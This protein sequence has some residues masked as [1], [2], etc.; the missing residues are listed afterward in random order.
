LLLPLVGVLALVPAVGSTPIELAN[1]LGGAIGIDLDEINNRLYFVEYTTGDLKCMDLTPGCE[2]TSPPSCPITHVAG[3]FVHPEGVAVIPELGV[4]FVTTRDDPGTTGALWK[5]ELATG[6]RSLVAFNL[7]APHQLAIDTLNN[8]AYVIGY[9]VGRLWRIDLTTGVK[10]TAVRDLD[11]PIGLVVS[12]DRTRAYITEQGAANRLAEYDLTNGAM[13]REVATGLTAPFFLDWADPAEISVYLVERNPAQDLLRIDLLTGMSVVAESGLPTSPSGVAASYFGGIAYV[14]TN[15]KILRIDLASLPLS[16]PV[17]LGVGHVP[18]SEI[19]ING[20]AT[21]AATYF[22]HVT[23]SPFGGTMNIFGNLSKFVDFGATHYRVQIS[24]DGGLTFNDLAHAWTAYRWNPTTGK[25]EATLVAPD[26]SDSRY[27]IPV[28]YPSNPQRWYPSFLM[29]RWP[30]SSNGL[31]EF[32]VELWQKHP[33]DTFT[34]IAAPLGNTLTLRIDNTPPTVD[35]KDILLHG[36]S[37]VIGPCDIVPASTANGYDFRITA[38]DP[39]HHLL[40]Y[41]LWVLW[42]KNKSDSILSDSYSA[43]VDAEGPYW[44]SG[45]SSSVKT[46]ACPNGWEASCNCAHTFRLRAWKRTI[47]GYH[48]ILRGDSHQSVTLNNAGS[49][50]PGCPMPTC[51]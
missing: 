3:S 34:P 40:S 26:P 8:T 14:T 9:D 32:R 21:T 11:H 35:L 39:N 16:E 18:A 22:Y 1:G 36:T 50:W 46:P 13:I 17:F 4:G 12:A 28:E 30:S 44:W 43:H 27:E 49:S 33:D 2:M 20:Y 24:A 38:H 5:V 15:S 29:M 7:G 41:H 31:Y 25:S 19:D 47:N 23:H 45:V 42:G 37:T 6:T 51:P 48:Y 10:V